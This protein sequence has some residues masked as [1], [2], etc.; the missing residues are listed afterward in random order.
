MQIQLR[1]EK[2]KSKTLN[3]KLKFTLAELKEQKLEIYKLQEFINNY[4]EKE[5][6]WKKIETEYKNQL[7][8][9]MDQDQEYLEDTENCSCEKYDCKSFEEVSNLETKSN[10]KIENDV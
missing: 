10:C 4:K 1:N 9:Y 5:L 7:N 2:I 8:S 3:E 6:L